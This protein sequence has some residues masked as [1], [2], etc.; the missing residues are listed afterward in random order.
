MHM[1][2]GV[3]GLPNTSVN[4]SLVLS[5]ATRC[6][7]RACCHRPQEASHVSGVSWY[8]CSSL[9]GDINHLTIL[10]DTGQGVDNPDHRPFWRQ[11]LGIGDFSE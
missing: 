8:H 3:E 10:E 6:V 5:A 2:A 1:Y 9:R 4:C 11:D 7:F